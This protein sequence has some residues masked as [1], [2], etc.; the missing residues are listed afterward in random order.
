MAF[1]VI[2]HMPAETLLTD[3]YRC[4]KRHDMCDRFPSKA[5]LIITPTSMQTMHM[6]SSAAK[7]I[8]RDCLML[9]NAIA[10]ASL[11]D[12]GSDI[13]LAARIGP[14]TNDKA[15]T[16][17]KLSGF[18]PRI[19]AAIHARAAGMKAIHR[20]MVRKDFSD[21]AAHAVPSPTAPINPYM[22]VRHMAVLAVLIANHLP[23]ILGPV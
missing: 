19:P 13:S 18:N 11:P 6:G 14:P 22:T 12:V 4:G 7:D 9:L 20:G 10:M 5:L 16:P 23:R 8:A 15:P 21:N 1:N 2:L 3:F 17:I